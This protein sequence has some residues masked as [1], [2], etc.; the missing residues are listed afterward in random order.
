MGEGGRKGE[1]RRGEGGALTFKASGREGVS[2]R[3]ANFEWE[4]MPPVPPVCLFVGLSPGRAWCPS[5]TPAFRVGSSLQPAPQP[6][7]TMENV[8]TGCLMNVTHTK[9]VETFRKMRNKAVR[10]R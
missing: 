6:G 7:V 10:R 4:G 9:T 3:C 2:H 5:P 8:G 1:S